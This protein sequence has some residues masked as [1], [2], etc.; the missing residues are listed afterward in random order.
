M[1]FP[2][3]AKIATFAGCLVVCMPTAFAQNSV[4]LLSDSPIEP[5]ASTSS[6]EDPYV[7]QSTIQQLSCPASGLYAVISSG[8]SALKT[9]NQGL[10]VLDNIYVSVTPAGGSA[11]VPANVC[12]LMPHSIGG[13]FN[14]PAIVGANYLNPYVGLD[15]DST[16]PGSNP[17]QT[18]TQAY[19]VGPIDIS[20]QLVAG[21]QSVVFQLE[22]ELMLPS[23]KTANSNLYLNTNCTST[24]VSGPVT[25]VNGTPPA[26]GVPEV[27]TFNN[28]P[29]Q[30]VSFNYTL[31]VGIG[32][33]AGLTEHVSDIPI[34]PTTFDQDYTYGTSFS[35]TSCYLHAGELLANNNP[36]C[37]MYTL[38][39]SVG[40][41]PAESG[42]LC[43]ASDVAN[44]IFGEQFDPPASFTLSLPDI[45][46][47]DGTY[48]TGVGLLMGPD[49]WTPG[50]ACQYTAGSIAADQDLIC[51]ENLL[52][53]FFG[54]GA[55]SSQGKGENVNSSFITIYGVPEP[56]TTVTSTNQLGSPQPLNAGN[57]TNNASQ[58]VQLSTTPP[59]GVSLTAIPGAAEFVAAPIQNISYGLTTLST[60]PEPP[61]EPI[62]A[63]TIL[64]APACPTVGYSG[65]P[66]ATVFTPPVQPLN[67][68]DGNAVPDGN[69]L[70]HYY[71][72]DCAGTQ[73][74]LFS[75]APGSNPPSWQ[76]TFYTYPINLDTTPPTVSISVPS[77]GATYTYGQ[78]VTAN[79]TCTDPAA[80]LLSTY[81]GIASC[82]GVPSTLTNGTGPQSSTPSGITVP[83]TTL[84]GPF[85]Y[86]VTAIDFA[87][88]TS[89]QSV[90][91]SVTQAP[92]T[93]TG[94][95]LPAQV[96]YAPPV[97]PIPLTATGGGS[98]LPVTY[99]VHA[100]PGTIACTPGCALTIT[101]LGTVTVY[102]NQ[103]GNADYLAAP[104]VV[105]SVVVSTYLA[106]VI[107]GLG[108]SSVSNT[109][110][111]VSAT[112]NP[113]NAA[114]S[115]F[116]AYGT[117]P[118]SLTTT[119]TPKVLA[120]GVTGIPVSATLTGLQANT[121]YY[122]RITAKSL[123][124][125]VI[126]STLSFITP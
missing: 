109:S 19:G 55:S 25:V 83:T 120:A 70:L 118:T 96:A 110:E 93:I 52:F 18:F 68:T 116:F 102:A 90:T 117:S 5:T 81:S 30:G 69:Y 56:L 121:T 80:G 61:S 78:A 45:A 98:G 35:T 1:N 38:L 119:T 36:A 13:C 12:P 94:F 92:Q 10:M 43:P 74:L 9:G 89:T 6:F 40:T 34:D 20:S 17:A 63:D 48:H 23:G 15:P 84:G 103:A 112:I 67:L 59:I 50:E 106:P 58:W 76:T 107:S 91:Y 37:K 28:Q 79:F 3:F 11:S 21:A 44:E 124:G 8:Q 111:T 39:C 2:R 16:I 24:G 32:G 64:N 60:L 65:T 27:F 115:Y 71:A 41:N 105:Q 49:V 22:S 77:Q 26:G 53:N 86:S 113:E 122:Y 100:G 7:F 62:A 88:N 101:G 126:A 31:P 87:G 125:Q 99:K 51:P 33:L 104:Q 114:T 54:P 82:G 75:V 85:T 29:N 46:T 57:W 47:P 42:A 97:A 14:E 4:L 66:P 73:E 108:A 72:Q 95:T 123:G